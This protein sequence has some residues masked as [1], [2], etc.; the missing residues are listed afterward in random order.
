MIFVWMT[1]FTSWASMDSFGVPYL[2][3]LAPLRMKKTLREVITRPL[4][5][6]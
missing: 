3:P 2:R 6:V 5:Q 4:K 1:I